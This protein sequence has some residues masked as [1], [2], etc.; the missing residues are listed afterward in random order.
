MAKFAFTCWV[1]WDTVIDDIAV[2]QGGLQSE[3][4]IPLGRGPEP[5]ALAGTFQILG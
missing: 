2:P 5:Q 4:W 1:T 3:A